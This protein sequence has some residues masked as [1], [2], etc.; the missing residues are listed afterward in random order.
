MSDA[1]RNIPFGMPILGEEEKTKV[2]EVL[3][4]PILVHGPRAKEFEASFAAYA[5]SRHALS[6][7]SCTAALHLAYFYLSIGPG[8]EVIVP[9]QTHVA[10]AHAVELCGAKPVF[11]DAENKAGNIDLE[12]I[13]KQITERTKAISV[14]HFLGMPVNM[15]RLNQIA[16]KNKLF[17]VED[18][19]LAIGAYFKGVHAGLHGDVGCFS[20][21]PVKHMT[22]GEGGM[23]LTQNDAIAAKIQRQKAFG[24]D[25]H[26]GER[27]VPGVYDVTMLGFNYRLGEIAAA[28]GIEQIKRLPF[29]LKRREENYR[30]LEKAL[31]EIPE[32]RLLQSS[33]GDYQSSYYCL[34]A[35]LKKPLQ[36]KRFEIV[37]LLKEKGVGT[38]V[39]YPRPVPHF[40]Y[41]RD[42]YG[43]GADSFPVAAEISNSSI[44]LPVGPHLS[45]EDMSYIAEAF[46]SSI[47]ASKKK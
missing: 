46:K 40:S 30:A 4:G 5:G 28:M 27:S 20:F 23:L 32:I 8:D 39:Y 14:V 43:Y 34:S 31:Q 15:E 47:L 13:E 35:L 2:M 37:S 18:C 44:S 29:F 38:S 19:A 25:R 26:M 33:H 12:Q 24:V 21:Y 11:V 16:K 1:F 6:V 3:S 22:T 7:S 42:K 41:Y 45:K 9:A 36:P 10:T 17:V